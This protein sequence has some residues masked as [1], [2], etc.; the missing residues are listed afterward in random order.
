MINHAPWNFYAPLCIY[1]PPVLY[2]LHH[3]TFW[4]IWSCKILNS[5]GISAQSLY[6][7]HTVKNFYSPLCIWTFS[8]IQNMHK[9]QYFQPA[10]C[11]DILFLS[12]FRTQK[13]RTPCI[14]IAY[15]IRLLTN[16]KTC[17]K[18]ICNSKSAV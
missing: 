11:F 8:I 18:L 4:V 1:T 17:V 9:Y 13:D 7:N 5:K 2:L 12:F 10:T 15:L 16:L 6:I 14:Y 3:S